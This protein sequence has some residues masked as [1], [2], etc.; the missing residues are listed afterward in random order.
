[1][2]GYCLALGTCIC[3]GRPMT[4]N[5]VTVPSTSA[6]TGSRE[7]I[8]R[9]CFTV[10]NAKRQENGLEPFVAAADAWEPCEEAAL[11]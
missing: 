1:M 10:I 2:S 5:P 9:D 6:V 8:C 3:C 7:P 4:F 11:G